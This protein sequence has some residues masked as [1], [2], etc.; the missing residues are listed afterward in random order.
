M[1]NLLPYSIMHP[2]LSSKHPEIKAHA[3]IGLYH[4]TP[5]KYSSTIASWLHSEDLAQR[6]AGIIAAGG[7]EDISFCDRLEKMLAD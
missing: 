7:S 5:E 4:R 3:L 2:F 1:L 6:K